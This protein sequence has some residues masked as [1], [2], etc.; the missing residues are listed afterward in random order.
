M[1]CNIINFITQ[2]NC[3]IL[4]MNKRPDDVKEEQKTKGSMCKYYKLLEY[5]LIC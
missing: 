4:A 1:S 3:C 5:K 2:Y